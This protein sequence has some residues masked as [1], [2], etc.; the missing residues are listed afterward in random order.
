MAVTLLR[1]YQGYTA[2]QVIDLPSELEAALVAQGL[3][4][5]GGTP[6]AGAL[7]T[8]VAGTG[9]QILFAGYANVAIAATSVVITIPGVT[10][11]N[12]AWAVIAQAAA[13]STFVTILRVN[14]TAN[15]V[16]VFGT[17]G[18]TAATRIAYFVSA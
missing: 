17:A 1:A 10:A 2:G 16:T 18:A 14:C 7:T 13:D 6:T 4:T 3:A 9:G 12:K 11:Q 15:T 8:T 5:A